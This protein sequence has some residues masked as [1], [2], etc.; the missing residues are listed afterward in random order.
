MTA[1]NK[2]HSL[3]NATKKTAKIKSTNILHRTKQ[4]TNRKSYRIP[5]DIEIV[6]A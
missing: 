2:A 5:Y 3:M 6:L 4:N 1:R